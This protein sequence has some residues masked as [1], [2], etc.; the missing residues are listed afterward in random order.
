V[1]LFVFEALFGMGCALWVRL[2]EALSSARGCFKRFYFRLIAVVG[3]AA[4]FDYTVDS[5]LW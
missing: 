1:P 4:G 3:I 2:R 5:F